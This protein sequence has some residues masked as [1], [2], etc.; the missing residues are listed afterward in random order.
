[1]LLKIGKTAGSLSQFEASQAVAN[2]VLSQ[3]EEKV[4]C[5]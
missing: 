3:A 5:Y 4:W 2:E 1:M